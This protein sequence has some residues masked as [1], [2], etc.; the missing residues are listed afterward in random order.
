MLFCLPFVCSACRGTR[1]VNEVWLMSQLAFN[2]LLVFC[3]RFERVHGV[4]NWFSGFEK[5]VGVHG[6]PPDCD[7]EPD[8]NEG[9]QQVMPHKYRKG[10]ASSRT[11]RRTSR[12]ISRST[13]RSTT[14]LGTPS[15]AKTSDLTQSM[16]VQAHFIPRVQDKT[17]LLDKA[18]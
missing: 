7:Q 9:M 4:W 6:E 5:C 13:T 11:A 15:R 17:C 12:R 8:M 2:G 16:K 1:S 14:W 10:I 18:K 3:C